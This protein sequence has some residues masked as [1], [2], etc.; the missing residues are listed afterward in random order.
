MHALKDMYI[1]HGNICVCPHKNTYTNKP[2]IKK[3]ERMNEREVFE[4]RSLI[5][6][7]GIRP[8]FFQKDMEFQVFQR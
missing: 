8:R 6:M 4:K 2:F 3:N 7:F 1:M 5:A